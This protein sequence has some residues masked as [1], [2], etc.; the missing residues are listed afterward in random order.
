MP[1]AMGWDQR[2]REMVFAGGAL[3]ATACGPS[4]ATSSDAASDGTSGDEAGDNVSSFCCNASSDPCCYLSCGNSPDAEASYMACRAN[5]MDCGVNETFQ[6]LDNGRVGCFPPPPMN[7]SSGCC[8]ANPDPCCALG[9]CGDAGPDSPVYIDCEQGYSECQALDASYASQPDGGF[10][11]S[12]ALDAG[13]AGAT[14]AAP[15]D[16]SAGDA[17][18]SP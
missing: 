16:A 1:V 3:A 9:Y 18:A 17:D 15:T 7:S 11:C 10:A 12:V 14:D 5:L 13:D 6:Q 4:T 2:L 8:N